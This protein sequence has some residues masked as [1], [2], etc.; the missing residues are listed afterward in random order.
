M[1]SVRIRPG[2]HFADARADAR[3]G[4]DLRTSASMNT[5]VTMPASASR[6]TTSRNAPPAGDVEAAFGRDLVP[7]SGTSIA[8]SGLMRH[9]MSIISSVP[10]ARG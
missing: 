8:I 2:V 7:P 1:E 3:R 4:L 10:R 5:D 9:A 6:R